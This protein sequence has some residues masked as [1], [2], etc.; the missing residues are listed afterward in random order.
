MLSVRPFRRWLTVIIPIILVLVWAQAA[1]AAAPKLLSLS[2]SSVA[3]GSPAFTLTIYGIAFT[4]G[5]TAKWG[6]NAL[7]TAYTS[8]TELTAVVPANLITRKGLF[9]ITVTAVGG[10]SS[11]AAFTIISPSR[12]V[13]GLGPAV[14]AEASVPASQAAAVP[15]TSVTAADGVSSQAALPVN[16]S[17]PASATAD[18]SAAQK[19]S[20]VSPSL[21]DADAV[22]S[23]Q[24]TPPV[25]PPSSTTSND[26]P[27]PSMVG[28]MAATAFASATNFKV[29]AVSGNSYGVPLGVIVPSPT[30]ASLSPASATAGGAAFTL[31][32]NGA[33]FTSAA[34]VSLGS[35]S[36]ATTYVSDT[37]LAATVPASL[38]AT[39]GASSVTVSGASNSAAFTILS[40]LPTITSTSPASVLA[41]VG[42]FTLTIN[43]SNFLPGPGATVVSWDYTAL[44][45]TYISS[46]QITAVV[47]ASLI[48]SARMSTSARTIGI[49]VSTANGVST[50][51]AFTINP[52]KPVITSL[53]SSNYW[54]AAG[55]AAVGQGDSTLTVGGNYFD[56]TAVVYWG[57]MPLVTTY[58]PNYSQLVAAVPASLTAT[59]G[60]ASLT[61]TSDG[62]TSA[63]VAF[64]ILVS[65][66]IS[67]LKP[68]AVFAGSD[69]FTLTINGS[70]F[71]P[72]SL[73]V[74]WLDASGGITFL[75]AT[76]ISPAQISVV[77]PASL[78]A[79]ASVSPDYPWVYV[80]ISI[81]TP[82][83][84]G[85]SAPI[86]FAIVPAPPAITS[87]TPSSVNAGGT[88]FSL[89]ITG[90][91]FIPGATT[92]SWGTTSLSTINISTTQLSVAVPASL[93]EYPGTGSITVVT[94]NGTSAPATFI[95][96]PAL[97]AISYLSPSWAK[98]GSSAFTLTI[99]GQYFTPASIVNWGSTALTTAY[100]SQTQLTAVVP[101]SLI[102]GTGTASVSVTTST[103]TSASL[104]FTI[105]PTVTI[106]TATLP[107]GTAGNAY[108]GPI[109][110]IGGS[111]GY[112]WTITGLP[113]SM[114]YFNTND[115]TLTITGTPASPG[116]ITFQVSVE[117]TAG[118][119]A[120]PINYTINIAAGPSG[121]NNS[122]LN[123]SYVCLFQGSVDT[124]GTRWAT[125]ANFQADGQG[126]F[127]NGVFDTNSYD[128]G[129]SSGVMT[130]SYSIG[131]DNNGM[132]SIH[133]VLTEGA[134]GIQ[135]AHWAIALA[136]AAQPAQ[137]FRMIEADD[138]GTLPAYQQATANCYLATT[139][140]FASSTISGSSFAFGL[141]G[142]DNSGNMKSVVGL[143][144]ASGGKIT[145]GNIDMAQGG[146]ATVQTAAFTA[147]YTA[148]DPAS[149]RFTM[150]LNGAGNSTGFA[151]YIIDANRMFILDNTN[152]DGALAGNMR[153][154]RQT[155]P[156]A[157][158]VSGTF[159]LYMRGAEFNNGGNAPTGFYADLFQ[160]TGDGAG[161]IT[162]NQSYTNDAGVYSA[163]NSN[164][165]P[166][167]L[168]FDSVHP[169]RATFQSASGTTYLYLFNNNSAFEMGVS[170]KGSV[171][172]G[173]LE[174]Q[175]QTAFTNASLA[176]NYLSADLSQLNIEPTSSVGVMDVTS[177]GAINAALSTASR[178]NLAWD[179]STSTTYS[180][181]ATAPGTGAFLIAD[182][183]QTG[184]SC[185][186]ISATKF[187]CA[188]QTDPAPSV[189]V[190]E[191]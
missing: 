26:S 76:Y 189:Q 153:T 104:P 29:N 101:A 123:G 23:T 24:D 168:A 51:F 98:A 92:V 155:T 3:S 19:A 95:I 138:L 55:T 50:Y 66:L 91:A 65:P 133:T 39:A 182:G 1:L 17:I 174:S 54:T 186:V 190:F 37:Q 35:T 121:A 171:E 58:Y 145:N 46:T 179:Q 33:N 159:V 107:P 160:G 181:D 177:A 134:A 94:A 86:G 93:I 28:G 14:A 173:W 80:Y 139:S 148:P 97:P 47:P 60:V 167:A 75:S 112:T 137:Q 105:N 140:A 191:Q 118:V 27:A 68:N 32:V 170:N 161:N 102:T 151:V 96:N 9:S 132:A 25:N 64:P 141:D 2:P 34:T 176:G 165:G 128:I 11:G 109:N 108:S 73:T 184:A 10:D 87:L 7:T 158:S 6:A 71:L 41:S 48:I 4:P 43:G 175:T 143:F 142:E 84:Y 180:W 110:V 72:T 120:G 100:I 31:T 149:G 126:N 124:D 162:I 172:S 38:I 106:T 69:S 152:N 113:H 130:G 59:A 61:V 82:G 88:G 85:W 116:A 5:S 18:Q 131:A 122:S 90:T 187:V 154:M 183:T 136:G 40:S 79:N 22:A 147:T 74:R 125:L 49:I 156:S 99:S 67:Y 115:S 36:L 150:N 56:S 164:N 185:A 13:P 42:S 135:T 44:A 8:D 119:V 114:T 111:P 52:A 117:D 16:S 21:V 157:A 166:A 70:N 89:I 188:S 63:P 45:T 178:G 127:T 78:I 81:Y 144:S 12:T 62:G 83:G 169:G 163:R 146:S 129:S 15:A 30:I 57:S 20:A 53:T 77:V 103:G